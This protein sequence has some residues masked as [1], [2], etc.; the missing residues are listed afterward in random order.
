[1]SPRDCVRQAAR[2]LRATRR[3]LHVRFVKEIDELDAQLLTQA[4]NEGAISLRRRERRAPE[5]AAAE[6]AR[7]RP[8]RSY[9]GLTRQCTSVDG[10]GIDQAPT[11]RGPRSEE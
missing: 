8:T 3:R 2:C 7:H 11:S 4:A 5:C 9:A 6:E 10:T 1:M